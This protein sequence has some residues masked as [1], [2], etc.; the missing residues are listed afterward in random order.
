MNARVRSRVWTL[1]GALLGMCCAAMF[2]GAKIGFEQSGQWPGWITVPLGA[3]AGPF[4]L[5]LDV[6]NIAEGWHQPLIAL[7]MAV[8]GALLGAIL[9]WTMA[10]E[11]E[12]NSKAA[13]LASCQGQANE[14]EQA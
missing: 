13:D 12:K 5:I 4:Y 2:V 10:R 3:V 14:E 8:P 6:L 9:G 11:E 1:L 7:P